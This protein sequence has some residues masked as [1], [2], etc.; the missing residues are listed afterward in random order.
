MAAHRD[1]GAGGWGG[2][3]RLGCPWR[4]QNV[5]GGGRVLGGPYC[6][7]I[8]SGKRAIVNGGQGFLLDKS[9]ACT[10]PPVLGWPLQRALLAGL[11]PSL[12]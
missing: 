3:V 7:L 5:P 8:L 1:P 11:A 2:L 6:S 10:G 12:C 4:G 9:R